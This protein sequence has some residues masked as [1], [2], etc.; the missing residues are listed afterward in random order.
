MDNNKKIYDIHC[1]NCGAPAC[2]DIISQNYLCSY[3]G[4]KVGIG[5]AVQQKQDFKKIHS[6]RMRTALPSF[7]L[8]QATCEGCGAA[9]VFEENEALSNCAFCG[10]TMVRD[11]YL[12]TEDLPS[13]IIPF[14]IT[15]KEAKKILDEWID[16]NRNRKEAGELSKIRNELKAFY[17]PY[18]LIR[19]PVS[20]SVERMDRGKRYSCEGF[21]NDEFVN[22]SKQLDNLLLDGMEPYD[23]E[24]LKEFDLAYVAGHRV[25]IADITDKELEKRAETETEEI[26]KPALSKTMETMVLDVDAD[27]GSA[28]KLPVLLPVYYI[29]KGELM[30]AING[31]TGKLSVRSLKERYYYFLPWW[32]KSIIATLVFTAVSFLAFRIFKADMMTSMVLSG[33]LAFFFLIVTLCLYS[34]TSHNS[35]RKVAGREIFTTGKETFKRDRDGLVLNDEILERKIVE[36]VFFEKINGKEEAVKLRFTTPS[37]VIRMAL[38]CLVALFLPVIIALF[39]NGFDFKRL[40][41]GGSAVWFCIMVP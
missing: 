41:L 28:I 9:I 35:F 31:Q 34:D 4:S 15:E 29:A 10:R 6:E 19:G 26:H 38:L 23:I 21:I 24:G 37:R 30:A 18:E 5:E 27:I 11:K 2:F 16:K 7:R 32:L 36:P 3:C 20:L 39:L 40:E 1:P 8:F 12:K 14:A 25:K 17:L 13:C 22:C 33:V